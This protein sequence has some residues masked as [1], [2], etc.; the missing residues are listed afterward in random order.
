MQITCVDDLHQLD[1]LRESWAAAYV[2][3]P[4]A[5]ICVSWAWLRGWFAATPHKWF[6]LV[7]RPDRSSTPVAFLP[8]ALDEHRLLMGGNPLADYTGFVCAPEH[9]SEAVAGFAAHVQ[10]RVR[11]EKF[12]LRNILDGRVERFLEHF[13]GVKFSVQVKAQ[14]SCPHIR[15]PNSWEQYL[16]ETVGPTTSRDIKRSLKK[17]D[18]VERFRLT[19]AGADSLDAHVETLLDHWHARWN[20]PDYYRDG[21]REIF[22]RSFEDNRLWLSILWDGPKPIGALAAFLDPVQK[23]MTA[24]ITSSD[25]SYAQ[26]R[27]GKV[28]YAYAIRYAIE[29]GYRIFD[30]TRGNEDYKFS[31]GAVERFS[32]SIA[33]A[34][35]GFQVSA[36]RFVRQLRGYLEPASS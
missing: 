28:V 6:V 33:I 7:A 36:R 13:A 30:F 23:T 31:F 19:C 24:C 11:W 2:T 18:G 17:V 9:E 8:L 5:T 21:F 4:Q 22:R 29:Q 34:R 26:L 12:Y 20:C 32:P 25:R 10:R 1:R 3:D 27:P 14:T 35:T 16:R 15:L